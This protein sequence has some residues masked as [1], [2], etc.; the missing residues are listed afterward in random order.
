MVC[1]QYVSKPFLIDGFKFDL[2]VY[3]LVTSCDPLRIF[4][5]EDGLGRFATLKYVDPSNNNLVSKVDSCLLTIVWKIWMKGCIKRLEQVYCTGMCQMWWGKCCKWKVSKTKI[6]YIVS[7]IKVKKWLKQKRCSLPYFWEKQ[8]YSDHLNCQ[9]T[10]ALGGSQE[11]V[12][13]HCNFQKQ[14]LR[15]N[16]RFGK[17]F[18]ANFMEK[19]SVKTA[20]YVTVFC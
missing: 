9:W 12:K 17:N 6:W 20:N 11:K 14:I 3:V 15:E 1:Q 8:R 18:G 16:S 4:V 10:R 19:Q 2:R 5:Y 7:M 13:F